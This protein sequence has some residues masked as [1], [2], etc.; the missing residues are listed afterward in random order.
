MDVFP[1]TKTEFETKMVKMMFENRLN[2]QVFFN[3]ELIEK[4][5]PQAANKG[6]SINLSIL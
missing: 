5:C 6:K 4:N 2:P 3:E 1:F